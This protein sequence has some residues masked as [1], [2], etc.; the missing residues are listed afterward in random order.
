MVTPFDLF[1]NRTG[2]FRDVSELSGIKRASFCRGGWGTRFIDFDNDGWKD[3]F[4]ATR[5]VM[6][7]VEE[8]IRTVTS[9][10]RLLMLKNEQGRFVEVSERIGATFR[11]PWIARG[12]AF[13]DF[14]N[15]GET[16]ILVQVLG[17]A[18]LF[19][20][21]LIGNQNHWAGLELVGTTSNRDASGAQ[22]KV[23]DTG[24]GEQHFFVSRTSSYLAIIRPASGGQGCAYGQVRSHSGGFRGSRC[25]AV[26]REGCGKRDGETSRPCRPQCVYSRREVANDGLPAVVR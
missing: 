5:H 15:D 21:K 12:A 10:Q 17:G 24:G 4:V 1:Q 19:L 7:H 6:G 22:V 18:P 2:S 13:G 25:E 16:D 11:Q 3:L 23:V 20:E 26:G 8:L 9:A 14:D